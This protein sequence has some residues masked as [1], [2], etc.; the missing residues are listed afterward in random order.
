MITYRVGRNDRVL[1]TEFDNVTTAEVRVQPTG[2][3]VTPIQIEHGKPI[4]KEENWNSLWNLDEFLVVTDQG[5][6]KV[7]V[8]P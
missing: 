2:T 8:L 7:V 6:Q 1:L 3:T 4:I 5:N